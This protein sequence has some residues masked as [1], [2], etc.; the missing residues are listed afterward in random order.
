MMHR[1]LREDPHEAGQRLTAAREAAATHFLEVADAIKAEAGVRL[2]YPRNT[3]S[4]RT[5][6]GLRIIAA[7]EG[8][9][10]SDIVC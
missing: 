10:R 5:W 8:R 1:P 9:T 4:G 3:L 2:H 6:P 7:P